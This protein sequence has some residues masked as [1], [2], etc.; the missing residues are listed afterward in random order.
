M[1][2]EKKLV[3]WILQTGEPLPTDKNFLRPMR[4]INLTKKLIEKGHKVVLWSSRFDHQSKEY[5]KI[6][7]QD[8]KV[9]ENLEIRLISSC[10]YKKNISI[11]RLID[12]AMLGFNLAKMLKKEK[13]LP[14]VAFLGFPPI[15]VNLVMSNWLRKKKIPFIVD[16]KDLW[17]DVFIENLIGLKKKFVKLIL[18][19]YFFATK[20]IYRHAE[21]ITSITNKFLKHIENFS[22]RDSNKR[23][24]VFPLV[25]NL[26]LDD[27][28]QSN[29][30]SWWDELGVYNDQT[31][32]V[33]YVGNLSSNINLYDIKKAA[34]SFEEKNIKVQFVIS[35]DGEFLQK[36]KNMMKGLNNVVFS[37]S[38]SKSKLFVLANRSNI[39]L[40][41]YLNKQNFLLSLPNKTYDALF[42]GLPIFSSL[43]GEVR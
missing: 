23:N 16:V 5:R 30:E 17:P 42:F 14:D 1:E 41:P 2:N 7:D 8:L 21:S 33:T 18:F 10:G 26:S 37:G 22:I 13:Q 12:H 9:N 25:S 39:W 19:Y 3:V 36:F 24:K 27:K 28:N 20:K 4:A 6:N 43:K 15:E 32:R 35:G 31:F 40:I 34:Q 29:V 38:I 11:K